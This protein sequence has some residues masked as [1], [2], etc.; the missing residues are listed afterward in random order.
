VALSRLFLW[1]A[2]Y[3]MVRALDNIGVGLQGS[4]YAQAL[5]AGKTRMRHL[6][7]QPLVTKVSSSQK[8]ERTLA[9]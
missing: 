4:K 7:S 2:I 3:F 5:K 6:S 1:V 8:H 9:V